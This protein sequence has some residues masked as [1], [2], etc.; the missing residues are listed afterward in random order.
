[1]NE[2]GRGD[3]NSALAVLLLGGLLIVN[4]TGTG[5]AEE[6]QM[7]GFDAGKEH[8]SSDRDEDDLHPLGGGGLPV[9]LLYS[10]RGLATRDNESHRL[11]FKVEVL[12]P[13]PPGQ[14]R[15]LMASNKSLEEI[16]DDIRSSG[17]EKIHR[18]SL[19]FDHS[20]YAAMNIL[21]L[22]GP[23]NSTVLRADLIDIDSLSTGNV[24]AILGRINITIP[25]FEKGEEAWGGLEIDRPP[26]EGR[27]S[28]LLDM[29]PPGEESGPG[30]ADGPRHG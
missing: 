20:L 30:K 18:G 4:L 16:R 26:H 22:P 23:D 17:G 9:D 10:G 13:M 8:L 11:R 3:L 24:S 27:Y 25:R 7:D 29:E 6:D 2:V 5:L 1:M 12:L 14:I 28:V 15:D 21:T 19:I